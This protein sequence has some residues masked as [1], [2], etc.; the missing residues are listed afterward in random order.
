[1][2]TQTTN[3]G[4]TKPS[5]SDNYD[6]GAYNAMVDTLDRVMK[7]AA[8]NAAVAASSTFNLSANGD[9]TY[10]NSLTTKS[11]GNIKGPQGATGSQGPKGDTGNTGATGPQGP[12][13]DTGNTGATGPQGPKGDT[14]ATG[15]Q[16]PKGDTGD[17]GATGPQGPKGDTGATGPQGPAGPQGPK[18][19]TGDT[20]ATGPQGPKGDTGDT[21]PAGPQGPKGDTAGLTILKYGTSTWNDFITAYST[22]SVIYCRASS[23]SDPSAGAQTRLAFM[24]YVNNETNPTEVEFQYY[25]S[26]ATH[27]DNQQG[28]Q[29]FVYKLNKT[30]GWTVTTRNAFTKI[31]VG[32]GLS[33][34]Y[35]NGVLTI[36]LA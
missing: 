31:A 13:G 4:F 21:G 16:G 26:V 9:L 11:L 7:N 35:S 17:T 18:G 8:D 34:S 6:I 25:R 10:V 24:A 1:M 36:S 30:A 33:S 3:Y 22:N 32:A 15:P 14:G 5:D 27:S 20:G 2:A 12:K 19:D 29:V 23:G 28:D